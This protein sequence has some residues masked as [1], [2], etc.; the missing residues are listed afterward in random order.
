MIFW[1]HCFFFCSYLSSHFSSTL[2]FVYSKTKDWQ[3]MHKTFSFATKVGNIIKFRLSGVQLGGVCSSMYALHIENIGSMSI[4]CSMCAHPSKVGYI[5]IYQTE[6]LSVFLS[7]F[8]ISFFSCNII[9]W[10][11][12][13][14]QKVS[15]ITSFVCKISYT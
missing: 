11:L 14:G 13:V 7:L 6:S 1:W 3:M 5:Y 8:K 10:A 4:L 2:T 9:F 12:A 15:K